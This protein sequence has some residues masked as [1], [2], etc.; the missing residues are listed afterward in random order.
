M[1]GW[2]ERV[3]SRQKVS[4]AEDRGMK[5]PCECGASY[6]SAVPSSGGRAHRHRILEALKVSKRQNLGLGS[7]N[8]EVL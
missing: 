7:Q 1:T 2:E 3:D 4:C 8:H 5:A 6:G